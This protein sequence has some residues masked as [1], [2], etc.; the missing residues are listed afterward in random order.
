MT[1][2]QQLRMFLR[3]YGFNLYQ[4]REVWVKSLAN[5]FIQIR[6]IKQMINSFKLTK[7]SANKS[8]DKIFLKNEHKQCIVER[9][10][11]AWMLSMTWLHKWGLRSFFEMRTTFSRRSLLGYFVLLLCSIIYLDPEDQRCLL[12]HNALRAISRTILM[13]K[14]PQV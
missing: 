5:A 12:R 7:D 13:R 11:S 4:T 6:G 14:S 9:R 8:S 10:K 3:L 1:G 2:T